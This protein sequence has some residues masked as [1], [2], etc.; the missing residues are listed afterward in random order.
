[1]NIFR[2]NL[3]IICLLAITISAQAIKPDRKYRFYP[4]KLG[5][6]YKDLNVKTSDGMSIKTWF[7]PAQAPLSAAEKDKAWET[8]VKRPY[9]TLSHTPR[10]TLVIC[11]GDA[12]NMSW[13]QL[14]IA[15]GLSAR[16]YN[17]VTFDWRG[18]GESSEWPMDSNYLC[19][20]EMLTDYNAVIAE[21][22]KQT[23]ADSSKIAVMGWSTGAYLSMATAAT[24]KNVAA[25]IG[26]GIPTDFDDFIPIIKKL[27]DKGDENLIVPADYPRHLMPIKIAPTF[28][29]PS[30]LI[31]AELDN[32]T[33][34][35]MCQKIYDRLVGPKEL[36]IVKGAEH[37]GMK[38]PFVIQF[39]EFIDRVDAFFGRYF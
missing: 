16:G 31:A 14:S 33:P 5:L 6:I 11:N 12:A 15:E 22:C 34:V 7:F 9:Q 21:V 36:W 20:T 23:E 13:F 37:G 27:L 25:Y 19:Y 29:K 4:E 24:N 38:S 32:R 3:L 17:V 35:W 30:L 18:F 1:M 10:P 8:A 39:D 28:Y 26:H 2:A